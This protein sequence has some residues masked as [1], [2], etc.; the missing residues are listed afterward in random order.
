[1]NAT[2]L[3]AVSPPASRYVCL[4]P[5]ASFYVWMNTENCNTSDSRR[6][7]ITVVML[8]GQHIVRWSSTTHRQHRMM[9]SSSGLIATRVF[10]LVFARES[11]TVYA[12]FTFV[13]LNFRAQREKKIFTKSKSHQQ[14]HTVWRRYSDLRQQRDMLVG[15]RRLLKSN[16]APVQICQRKLADWSQLVHLDKVSSVDGMSWQET[17]QRRKYCRCGKWESWMIE[18]ELFSC[19]RGRRKMGE[20]SRQ[21]WQQQQRQ[22]CINKIWFD[23]IWSDDKRKLQAVM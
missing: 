2:I 3:K 13:L 12:S 4:P 22:C 9:H 21:A 1:M 7:S 16:W 8:P 15:R 19:T 11:Y 10:L 17:R 23:L 6:N 14:L 20:R 5:F 18:I